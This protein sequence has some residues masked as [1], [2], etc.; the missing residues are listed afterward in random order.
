MFLIQYWGEASKSNF[1]HYFND[2]ILIN[3]SDFEIAKH[4]FFLKGF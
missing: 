3:L 1:W 2:N 4:V